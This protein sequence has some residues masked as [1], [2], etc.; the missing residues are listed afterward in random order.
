M[1]KTKDKTLASFLAEPVKEIIEGSKKQYYGITVLPE[2][3]TILHELV[4]CGSGVAKVKVARRLYAVALNS[5][6]Q[7]GTLDEETAY[8]ILTASVE[9]EEEENKK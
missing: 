8:N 4:S 3:A 1:S 7:A 9:E 5:F 2:H 6:V